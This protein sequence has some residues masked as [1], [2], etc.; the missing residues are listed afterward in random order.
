MPASEG[1]KAL[2]QKLQFIIY[3]TNQ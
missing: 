3:C 1:W 2:H